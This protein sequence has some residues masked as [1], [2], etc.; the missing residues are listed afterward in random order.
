MDLKRTVKYEADRDPAF[1]IWMSHTIGGERLR[2][3]LQCGMCSAACP[4]SSY[5]DYTPRRLILLAREGF[6]Q[7]VLTSSAIWLC[8]SCY[9]CM[10]GC[11]NEVNLTH[12]MYAL[13]ER[14]IREGYYPKRFP[15][16]IMAR[17]FAKMV[18]RSGRITESWLVVGIL[19]RS[20]FLRL[21]GMGKLGLK[22][23]RA[24]RLGLSREHIVHQEEV[25]QLVESVQTAK[26]RMSL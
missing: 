13:K 1:K 21:F 2:D 11:G 6:K 19:L 7:E 24:G 4:L 16:P 14:A 5:M 9:A 15:I 3:C 22:L 25:R 12:M 8:T 10:V 20:S 17:E 23:M 26:E 18:F